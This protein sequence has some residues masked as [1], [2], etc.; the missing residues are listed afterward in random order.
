ME[1]L[2]HYL[3]A[4]GYARA[5]TVREPGEFAV[6]GGLLDLFPPGTDEPLRLDFFG[7][8][9]ESIR[10]FDASTQMTTHQR[11]A[12][13]LTAASEVLLSDDAIS[14]FR[15]GY[16]E[17]FGTPGDDPVYEAVSE[18]RRQAG[19]EHWLPLFYEQLGTLFD[20]TGDGL[21]FLDHL[22]D[23]AVEERFKQIDDYYEAR[24]EDMRAGERASIDTVPYRP[25][26]PGA[27]YL[28]REGWKE[29]LQG[30]ALRPLSP[31]SGDPGGRVFDFGAKR[32]RTF[33]A[34]RSGGQNVF[35][36][37]ASHIAERRETKTVVVAGWTEGSADRLK[38]V[39]MDH[40]V[41]ERG[42]DDYGA[43]YFLTDRFEHH[44]ETFEE[45]TEHVT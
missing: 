9:L 17:R 37:V 1:E 6:R 13:G 34:E 32:G 22:G 28:T 10:A 16:L 23:E 2:T 27:L 20:Y 41:V 21:T 7:D 3:L 45:I 33:A 29:T 24:A 18:G 44:R 8:T 15:R 26:K 39:L 14:R 5:S 4:N 36:A 35:N 42:G 31:F 40:D 11:K 25:L 30:Q 12:I 19:M 38:T 43:M